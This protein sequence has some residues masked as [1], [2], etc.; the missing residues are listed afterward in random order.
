MIH[1]ILWVRLFLV[2]VQSVSF[3]LHLGMIL[4]I[5]WLCFTGLKAKIH[6]KIVKQGRPAR[7]IIARGISGFAT[8]WFEGQTASRHKRPNR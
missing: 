3:F 2:R 4:S 8:I 5:L 6:Q 1:V 7:G